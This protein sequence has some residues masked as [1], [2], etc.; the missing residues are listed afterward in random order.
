MKARRLLMVLLGAGLTIHSQP[1][2]AEPRRVLD[3]R[4]HHLGLEG[5]RE[6]RDLEGTVP[7]ARSLQITFDAHANAQPSTLFIRQRDVKL[8]W[9]VLLNGRKLGALDLM[10][11]PEVTTITV[12]AGVLRDGENH[13]SILSPEMP[14]DIF[15]EEIALDSRAPAEACRDGIIRVHVSDKESR[16]RCLAG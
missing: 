16:R 3:D 8:K 5:E 6:W 4:S 7:E 9:T 11:Y 13:L 2:H 1:I 15:I 14:D 12:S 10:E